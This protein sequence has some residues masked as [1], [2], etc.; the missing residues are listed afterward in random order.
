RAVAPP[1]QSLGDARETRRE[2]ERLDPAEDALQ[3]E[4]E[5]EQ[6]AA[7][8]VH[9]AR[10]VAEQDQPDLLALALAEAQ[11]DQIALG[12]VRAQRSPQVE[13]AAPLPGPAP[14]AHAMGQAAGDL[15]G[16]LEQIVELVGAE[17]GKVLVHQRLGLGG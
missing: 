17:G 16:E 4:Q 13:P 8:E 6:E 1:A 12:E 2:D 10:D 14:A 3:R 15:H 7:V 11:V 9:R 5:L